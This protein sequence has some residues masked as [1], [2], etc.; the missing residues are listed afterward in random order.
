LLRVACRIL[1]SSGLPGRSA[2]GPEHLSIGSHY[3][4]LTRTRALRHATR[5]SSASLS[6]PRL[7]TEGHVRKVHVVVVLVDGQRDDDGAALAVTGDL[8][9]FGC[10]FLRMTP[11]SPFSSRLMFWLLPLSKVWLMLRC[12]VS[13][14]AFAGLDRSSVGGLGSAVVVMVFLSR[15]EHGPPG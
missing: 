7:A 5:T 4:L 12:S 8:V 14:P 1:I 6:S 10:P 15:E 3:D 2:H 11:M 13:M 9:R